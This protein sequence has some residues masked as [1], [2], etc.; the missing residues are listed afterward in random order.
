MVAANL[1]ILETAINTYVDPNE[2][3]KFFESETDL[4]YPPDMKRFLGFLE[5]SVRT[6][7]GYL[8]GLCTTWAAEIEHP[9][10]KDIDLEL[11]KKAG[12]TKFGYLAK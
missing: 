8:N 6:S 5:V 4:M 3:L 9:D 11:W 12:E 1:F 10:P 2:K 7:I